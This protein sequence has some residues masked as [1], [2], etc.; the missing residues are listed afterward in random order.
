MVE[1]MRL[2]EGGGGQR[3][4]C[5]WT[6]VRRLGENRGQGKSFQDPFQMSQKPEEDPVP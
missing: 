2:L 5:Q 6:K 1:L 4:A 3:Q